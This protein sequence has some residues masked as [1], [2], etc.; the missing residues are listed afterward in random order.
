M[1]V[2][3][4]IGRYDFKRL[5]RRNIPAS[6]LSL[7]ASTPARHSRCSQ[8]A[9]AAP[10]AVQTDGPVPFSAA[11]AASA[12][13]AEAVR[14][15]SIPQHKPS[16]R[17]LPKTPFHSPALRFVIWRAA[18]AYLRQSHNTYYICRRTAHARA[19]APSS[20]SISDPPE[21]VPLPSSKLREL[22]PTRRSRGP[23]PPPSAGA[24]RRCT[25]QA[26]GGRG[27]AA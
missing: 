1:R 11:P 24:G 6:L 21:T 16:Q 9:S 13:P 15:G 8:T 18:G 22:R 25:R 2:S 27:R 10:Q 5:L 17:A 19:A 4:P 26:A 7:R 12:T 14:S 3:S 23:P 20:G